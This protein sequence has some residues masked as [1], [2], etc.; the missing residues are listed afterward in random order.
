MDCR[1]YKKH[2]TFLRK[3]PEFSH[4]ERQL[5]DPLTEIVNLE[6]ANL[7]FLQLEDKFSAFLENEALLAG[8]RLQTAKQAIQKNISLRYRVL[9]ITCVTSSN[10]IL[11][12]KFVHELLVEKARKRNCV[13]ATVERLRKQNQAGKI[14]ATITV[15]SHF[16]SN[17]PAESQMDKAAPRSSIIL[18]VAKFL[19]LVASY[20]KG[21]EMGKKHQVNV[22]KIQATSM[23]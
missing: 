5:N 13:H 12:D 3:I 2:S 16:G 20:G 7:L 6:I 4:V 17:K 9:R 10:L 21:I 19:K 14:T 8:H 1:A 11:H 18:V 23:C 22:C 15:E